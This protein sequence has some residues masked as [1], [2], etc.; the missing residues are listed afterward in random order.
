MIKVLIALLFLVMN[1]SVG[2]AANPDQPTINTPDPHK[3]VAVIINVNTV[4]GFDAH[5]IGKAKGIFYDKFKEA[6]T[7]SYKIIPGDSFS[8]QLS[9]SGFIN[10]F[11]T[12]KAELV[13]IFKKENV[14]YLVLVDVNTQVILS[15]FSMTR[16]SNIG[17]KIIDVSKDKY[18]YVNSFIEGSTLSST[19]YGEIKT[20]CK[21]INEVLI[22]KLLYWDAVVAKLKDSGDSKLYKLASSAKLISVGETDITIEVES[23]TA[24]M[25][26]SLDD[27]ISQIEALLLEE[28]GR[29][30][31]IK[32][33]YPP[34][35]I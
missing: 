19:W 16:T 27:A 14:H 4:K 20:A 23:S 32:I 7:P 34:K 11:S 22:S 29:P 5:S 15:L 21:K 1:F 30:L 12:E 8:S 24:K 13:P 26:L 28:A 6:L 9:S 10:A 33:T 31:K 18:L 25:L 2:L 35:Q 17:V 3:N